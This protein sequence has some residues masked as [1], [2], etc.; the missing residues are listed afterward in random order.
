[1]SQEGNQY[2]NLSSIIQNNP[3]EY[4]NI[5]Q[6]SVNQSTDNRY[7]AQGANI[8]NQPIPKDMGSFHNANNPMYDINY[9]SESAKNYNQQIQNPPIQQNYYPNNNPNM[10]Q[11]IGSTILDQQYDS[12]N[13]KNYNQPISNA[14]NVA[15]DSKQGDPN[16][17][18]P[19]TMGMNQYPEGAPVYDYVPP[20][21]GPGMFPHFPHFPHHPHFPHFPHYPP[22]PPAEDYYAYC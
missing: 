14:P 4:P 3:K 2:P 11:S 18:Y 20:P 21:H 22:Y 10:S 5:S 9:D 15:Y 8:Q 16:Y 17:N 1:M 12:N 7:D 19:P 13:A 6:I